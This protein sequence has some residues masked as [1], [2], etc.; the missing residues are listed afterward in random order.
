[1]LHNGNSILDWKHYEKIARS[2]PLEQLLYSIRDCANAA[3]Q[4]KGVFGSG[5][6]KGEGF[7]LDEYSVYAKELR[8]RQ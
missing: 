4:L 7:Y 8:R 5:A 2:M 1:M 3:Q 6:C